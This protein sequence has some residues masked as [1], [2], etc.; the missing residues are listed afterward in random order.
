MQPHLSQ[1]A[2]LARVVIVIV[3]VV[4]VYLLVWFDGQISLSPTRLE[5]PQRTGHL[6]FAR[7]LG[8][9]AYNS[10]WHNVR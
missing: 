9:G 10:V 2:T 8:P 4:T 3:V 5:S 6:Y 1:E 7:H